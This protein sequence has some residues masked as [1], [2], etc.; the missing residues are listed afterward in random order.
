GG[1][2]RVGLELADGDRDAGQRA[3]LLVEHGAAQCAERR[4]RDG[5]RREDQGS[6]KPDEREARDANHPLM[7]PCWLERVAVQ[8]SIC[9]ARSVVKRIVQNSRSNS[10][11]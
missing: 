10:R 8:G 6:E 1:L 9:A 11:G 3:A 7:L 5:R 2:R 4:L